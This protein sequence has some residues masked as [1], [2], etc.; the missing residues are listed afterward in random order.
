MDPKASVLPT[1][2]QRPTS[3]PG[4]V[5]HDDDDCGNAAGRFRNCIHCHSCAQPLG[6]H[7]E[8]VLNQPVVFDY[9]VLDEIPQWNEAT[10]LD[11]SPTEDEVLRV[12]R[13][14]SSGKSLLGADNSKGVLPRGRTSIQVRRLSRLFL[15]IWDKKANPQ[16]FEDA[17]VVHISKKKGDQEC[18]DDHRRISVLSIAVK[19]LCVFYSTGYIF[20][21]LLRVSVASVLLEGLAT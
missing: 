17:L 14:L 18:C 4:A 5:G 3:S 20:M 19:I 7:F 6:V 8:S 15:K 16:D 2:P 21:F 10:H 12:I 1:T 11:Q 13:M 9:S